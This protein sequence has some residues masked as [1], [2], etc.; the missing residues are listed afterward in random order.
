MV[1]LYFPIMVFH[2]P[3][4]PHSQ[5]RYI[6]SPTYDY[7]IDVLSAFHIFLVGGEWLPFSIFP[8]IWGISSCQLTNSIIFQDGVGR[9]NHQ[10]VLISHRCPEN[11][12]RFPI[13]KSHDIRDIVP[14]ALSQ[15]KWCP[16]SYVNVSLENP[17]E[18]Y[19]Y[20]HLINP[21]VIVLMFIN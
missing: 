21:N 13:V 16:P 15:Q 18:Y 14:I 8:E 5:K 3:H 7:P 6:H 11:H 1:T 10:P 4:I 20:N 12:R 17:H 19:R 9:P 2:V